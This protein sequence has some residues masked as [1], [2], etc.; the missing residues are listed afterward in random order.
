MEMYFKL[1]VILPM[2]AILIVLIYIAVEMVK[3]F[4]DSKIKKNCF[5]CKYYILNNFDSVGLGREYKCILKD[6]VD[7]NNANDRVNL[8]KCD[9]FSKK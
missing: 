5:E 7:Y 2:I 4:I 8:F 9:G 6:R 1:K 3:G